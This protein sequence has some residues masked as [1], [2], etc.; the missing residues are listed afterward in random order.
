MIRAYDELYLRNAMGVLASS[1]DYAVHTLGYD[2]SEYY[3]MFI[4]TDLAGR[5]EHGDPFIVS[6]KSGIELAL[7]VVEKYSGKYEYR[8]CS[9]RDGRSREYWA[10]WAL[11]YYQWY[12]A[13]SL[14]RLEHEIKITSI[15]DMYDKY[16]EM[17]IIQFVDRIE[18]I[19]QD[20]RMNAYLKEYRKL[21]GYSQGELA[22]LTGIPIKTIQQY[23][24]GAKSLSRANASY[25]LALAR[26]LKCEPEAL[27]QG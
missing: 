16:H 22:G 4:R 7:M 14:R 11:A 21:G 10:G 27:I 23:E 24:Q 9:Y 26:A 3:N 15:L 5:F 19:R 25:V 6:G 1:L 20:V 18:E 12:S 2:L 17:D 13:C 8:D